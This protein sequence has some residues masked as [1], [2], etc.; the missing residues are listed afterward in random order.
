MKK[1]RWIIPDISLHLITLQLRFCVHTP[2]EARQPWRRLHWDV[3]KRKSGGEGKER[4]R[5]DWSGS[6]GYEWERKRKV[7]DALREELRGGGRRE[8]SAWWCLMTME[9]QKPWGWR[10]QRVSQTQRCTSLST[11]DSHCS[12]P[13]EPE[14]ERSNNPKLKSA[15]LNRL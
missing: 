13:P 14:R 3:K 8:A 6:N 7:D 15:K 11:T 10:I 4:K 12:T 9:H 1:G 5:W 2:P